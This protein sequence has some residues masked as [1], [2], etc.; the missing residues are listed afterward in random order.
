MGEFAVDVIHLDQ[1]VVGDVGFGEEHVHVAGHAAGDGV[2]GE[3]HVHAAAGEGIEQLAD[4]VLRLRHGEAV[5]GDDDDTRG[6]FQNGGGFLGAGGTDRATLPLLR[7]GL[8]LAEGA[9]QNVGKGAVH[10]LAHDNRKNQARGTVESAGDD[11]QLVIEREAHGAGRQAGV[12]IQQGDDCGHVC[13]A[14]GED[15]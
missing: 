10:G 5:S 13:A 11:Q 6:R 1:A 7:G 9:E 12:R 4:L 2:D 15:Q 3:L 8:Q 14:D